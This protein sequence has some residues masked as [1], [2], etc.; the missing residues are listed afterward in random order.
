MRQTHFNCR[1]VR[2]SKC[3]VKKCIDG[4]LSGDISAIHVNTQ[5]YARGKAGNH[6]CVVSL[7]NQTNPLILCF[8]VKH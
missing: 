5:D 3:K 8:P 2:V 1:A 4:E 7:S 6:V